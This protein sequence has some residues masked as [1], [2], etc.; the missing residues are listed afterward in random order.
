MMH[1]EKC[2]L[3]RL[4]N[5]PLKRMTLLDYRSVCVLLRELDHM[6]CPMESPSVNVT[7]LTR[8][9]RSTQ[10]RWRDAAISLLS[11]AADWAHASRNFCAAHSRARSS[12]CWESEAEVAKVEDR[13]PAALAMCREKP[14]Q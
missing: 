3:S 9:V 11:L 1:L 8:L 13:I 6:S 4:M 14:L 5:I 10:K 2:N 12:V 7:A